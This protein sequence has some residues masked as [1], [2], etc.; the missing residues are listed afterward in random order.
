METKLK[1]CFP[2]FGLAAD[3]VTLPESNAGTLRSTPPPVLRKD[4]DLDSN[5]A[6]TDVEMGV[7]ASPRRT[8]KRSAIVERRKE[9][10]KTAETAKEK[11]KKVGGARKARSTAVKK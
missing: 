4:M 2:N 8:V 6:S 5:A 10:L 3:A 9:E 1:E 7:R 11:E